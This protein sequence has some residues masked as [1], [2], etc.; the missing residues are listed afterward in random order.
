MENLKTKDNQKNSDFYCVVSRKELAIIWKYSSTDS[1][2]KY[3]KKVQQSTVSL[4]F[5]ISKN[6]PKQLKFLEVL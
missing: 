6:Y 2:R 3:G 5:S 1:I 4:H